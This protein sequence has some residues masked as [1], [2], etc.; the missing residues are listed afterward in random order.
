[1]NQVLYIIF[2]AFS[3]LKG[4]GCTCAGVEQLT[5]EEVKNRSLIFI[6]VV[7]E[8]D[9]LN[10]G[11]EILAKFKIIE[12]LNNN[13]NLIDTV[14]VHTNGDSG[15][16]GVEFNLNERWYIFPDTENNVRI[17]VSVCG[18][19]LLLNKNPI[20]RKDYGRNYIKAKK[21]HRK[22]TRRFK[23]EKRFIKKFLTYSEQYAL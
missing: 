6:G 11:A 13:G 17:D 14:M 16:C 4:Y 22:E 3:S 12:I 2:L 19:S 20:T 18:R 23:S 10:N 8:I 15:M 5:K 1:M 21:Y 7:I 9:T